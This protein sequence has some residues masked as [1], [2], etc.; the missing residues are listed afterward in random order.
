M[1]HFVTGDT[2]VLIPMM[3]MLLPTIPMMVKLKLVLTNW[4]MM[5]LVNIFQFCLKS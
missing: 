1:I 2:G 5:M 4:T 3:M